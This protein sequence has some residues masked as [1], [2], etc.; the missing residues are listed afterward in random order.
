MGLSEYISS[1]ISGSDW[2]KMNCPMKNMMTHKVTINFNVFGAFMKN[3][4]VSNLN[5]TSIVTTNGSDCGMKD[6]HIF[7]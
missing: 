3:V 6:P 2:L 5:G 1:L 7:K 4:V